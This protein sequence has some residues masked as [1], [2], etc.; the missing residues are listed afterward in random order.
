[1]GWLEFCYTMISFLHT[2]VLGCI[3]GWSGWSGLYVKLG[4]GM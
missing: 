3:P 2:L 1:M 4:E